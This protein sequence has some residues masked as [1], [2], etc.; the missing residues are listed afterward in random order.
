MAKALFEWDTRLDRSPQDAARRASAWMTPALAARQ[1]VVTGGGGLAW[2]QLAVVDG[3]TT[4]AAT[5]DTEP[6]PAVATGQTV[7]RVFV[8]VMG[9]T[10]VAATGASGPA[11]WRQSWVV[12]I[13]LTR[14]PQ[15][16]RVAQLVEQPAGG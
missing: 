10:A 1:A 5:L 4:A 11:V 12:L 15:G 7:R 16:W 3:Y 8:T 13:S 14:L 6:P 9:V 2:S